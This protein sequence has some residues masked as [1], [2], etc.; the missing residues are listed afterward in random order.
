MNRRD[1]D[2]DHIDPRWE[3]G[4]DYQLVCGRDCP[5]NYKEEY[6]TQNKRKN[7]RFLPWRWSR[8]EI[9]VV[10]EEYGD[11][12]L[13][14]VGADI[15]N[16]LPGEWVLMEF[17]SEEWFEATT[18]TYGLAIAHETWRKEFPEE[19]RKSVENLK[20]WCK[21]NRKESLQYLQKARNVF[22]E[23]YNNMTEEELLER[24]RVISEATKKA[25]AELPPDK[26]KR[27]LE[28][29]RKGRE[30]GAHKQHLQRWM[31]TVTGYITTPAPLSRYQ[32]ARGIDPLNR[33][34]VQ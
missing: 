7:N 16:D 24:S 25:M 10:P 6:P 27:Q 26:K 3:E 19:F 8:D 5:A 11:L 9:G 23:K 20:K 18:K 34:R 17:L 15:E 4:R 28:G 12:A 14:L 1:F 22:K 32:K 21:E 31:C 13:F 30:K 33:V 2:I 29:A